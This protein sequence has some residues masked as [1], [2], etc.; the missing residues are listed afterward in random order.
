M[1]SPEVIERGTRLEDMHSSSKTMQSCK[2]P[3]VHYFCTHVRIVWASRMHTGETL[4]N[5]QILFGFYATN[6]FKQSININWCGFVFGPQVNALQNR[7]LLQP[8]LYIFRIC[9][10]HIKTE[11]FAHSSVQPL[12]LSQA[13]A[14]MKIYF[15]L[16][17]QILYWKMTWTLTP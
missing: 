13:I 7:L 2:P 5:V 12:K 15:K 10:H 4:E 6:D 8:R 3:T 14:F 17:P 11:I 9:L 1:A 16:L